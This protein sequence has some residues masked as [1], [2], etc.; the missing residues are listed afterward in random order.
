MT[1]LKYKLPKS[2][3]V[4]T[5]FLFFFNCKTHKIKF[6]TNP[7]FIFKEVYFQHFVGGQPGN[8]GFNVFIILE[9]PTDI[10]PDSL[11]FQERVA[12]V[13]IRDNQ[14]I[15]RFNTIK[16]NEINLSQNQEPNVIEHVEKMKKFPF[17]LL[18]DQAVLLYN[19]NNT[20]YYYK[21][22]NIKSKET[23]YFP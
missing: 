5:F 1:H 6:E 23:I 19:Y 15:A 21:I 17:K 16:R 9:K 22:D 14:W 18:D 4:L 8:A 13:E 3:T 11:Y 2:L 7:N 12:S 10:K 20:R